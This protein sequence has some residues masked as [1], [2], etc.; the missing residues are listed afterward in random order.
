MTT[1][2]SKKRTQEVLGSGGYDELYSAQYRN[3]IDVLTRRKSEVV[4]H[5]GVRPSVNQLAHFFFIAS[6][7]RASSSSIEF[8]NE[9]G[10]DALL[11][12]KGCRS[13]IQNERRMGRCSLALEKHPYLDERPACGSSSFRLHPSA[14]VDHSACF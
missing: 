14:L 3:T 5:D 8:E 7:H 10:R 12:L 9:I 2:I 13:E 1:S 4:A 6:R 11:H